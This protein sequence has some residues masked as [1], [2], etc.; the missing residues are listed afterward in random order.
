MADIIAIGEMLVDFTQEVT[1]DGAVRFYRNPGGAPAMLAV[2]AAKLGTPSAF[3]GKL[4]KDMFGKYLKG[5]LEKHGVDTSGV[6][7]DK[8]HQT[9]LAFVNKDEDNER[10][11]V[12]YR[13]DSAD[14]NLTFDEIKKSQL[15]ECKIVHFGALSLTREPMRSATI[16]ALEYAKEHGKIISY[17]P[18]WREHL[19]DSK[20][21]AFKIMRSVLPLCD[22][23]KVS[24]KELKIVTD[25]DNMLTGAAILLQKGIKAV[26]VTQGAKGCIIATKK[27]IV[28]SSSYKVES[29]DTLGTGD[30]F[31]G[32]FLSMIAK[33]GKKLEE[34]DV[35]ELE[36][37]ADYANAC[38]ALC[39]TKYGA[40]PSMPTEEEII[41]C[42]KTVQKI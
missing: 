29:I 39:S 6:I 9:T 41:N 11:F 37:M 42:M 10:D 4:G 32:A 17:D 18:N 25:Y 28:R 26:I 24:E 5:E 2:M 38:G 7:L 8:D 12:F 22:I 19:W 15:D 35:E 31:M 40:I 20:E 30:S 34:I 14:V 3:I 1:P 23:I 16:N 33:S 36:Y 21:E 13:T 27:S